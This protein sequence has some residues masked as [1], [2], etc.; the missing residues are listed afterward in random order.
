[1]KRL[2]ILFFIVAMVM[3]PWTAFSG[4]LRMGT[5]GPSGNYFSMGNDIASYCNSELDGA[6]IEVMNSDGAVQNLLGL[7]QKEFAIGIVQEDVLQYYAKQQPMDVNQNRQKIIAGLHIEVAH[8]LI[9]LDYEP[10]RDTGMFGKLKGM[11]SGGESEPALSLDVLKDQTIGSWGGSIISAKALSYFMG[12]NLNVIELSKDKRAAPNMPIFLVGGQ[13]Y[14]PV[15]DYL[16]TGKYALI[17]I[18]YNQLASKAPFYIKMDANYRIGG[19]IASIPTFGVRALL[20]GK[21]YRNESRNRNMQI[22]GKCISDNL[23]DLA[24]DSD[25]NPNWSTV[26]DLEQDGNQTNWSYFSLK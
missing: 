1:M 14:K 12:L 7:Y 19:K 23:G 24:D 10:E 16:S 9:P 13:P 3:A 8:L 17:P 20:L 5:G 22:L 11:F 18:D 25:T 26:Y 4:T 2:L 21:S 15:Q 6:A